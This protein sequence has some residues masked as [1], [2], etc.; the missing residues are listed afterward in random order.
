[1][2]LRS[3]SSAL[4]ATFRRLARDERGNALALIA[5]GLPFL[6]GCAGLAV[7]TIQWVYAKRNLQSAVDA[8]AVAGVYGLIQGEGMEFA[9]D[10]SLTSSPN[11]PKDRAVHAEQSPE[12]FADDP[13]AVR[14]RVTSRAKLTFSSLFL[15]D[16]PAI[17]VEATARVVENGEF[18]AFAMGQDEETGLTIEPGADVELGCGIATNAS[19]KEALKADGSSKLSAERVAALGG[20]VGDTIDAPIK[21]SYGLSQKDPLEGSEPPLVPNTGCPNVT[22]NPDAARFND[23]RLTL[24]PGCYGNLNING[25]VFLADGEY[26]LSRG[27]LLVGPA[28]ELSCRA[29]T[30]FLTSDKPAEDPASIGKVQIDSH[31]KVKL[32]APTEGPNAGILIYQD[33]HA[34]DDRDSVENVVSGSSFTELKGLIYLPSE[35]L[36]ID[37]EMNPDM[38]CARFVGRRLIFKGRV[39]IAT[40]CSGAHVMNFKG[41]D[42]KLVG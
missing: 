29:C 10:R 41:S 20:I 39:L 27:S 24:Q 40:G 22:I 28:A 8:A 3:A 38:Q 12:G 4:C 32:A 30:I 31:A 11:L 6:I 42:V 14:V 26:I 18:C 15:R 5:F 1:M 37:G 34:G 25:P 33:R 7:D 23:G 19:S 9:V 13:L 21:R 36:R 35:I 2:T 16:A 17:T